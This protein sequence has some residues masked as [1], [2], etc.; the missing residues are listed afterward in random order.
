MSTGGSNLH[1]FLRVANFCTFVIK[2]EEI[3]GSVVFQR[4]DKFKVHALN[5]LNI[6]NTNWVIVQ[7]CNSIQVLYQFVIELLQQ[8]HVVLHVA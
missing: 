7:S 4:V 6:F 3:F 5:K 2:N 1:K 8:Y